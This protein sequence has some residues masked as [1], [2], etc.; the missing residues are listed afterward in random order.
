MV[1]VCLYPESSLLERRYNFLKKERRQ[2][3]RIDRAEKKVEKLE[4]R[5]RA[6][7][8]KYEAKGRI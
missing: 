3:R 8:W 4:R 6:L 5:V 2:L 7:R 1:A